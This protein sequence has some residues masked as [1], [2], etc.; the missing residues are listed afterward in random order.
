MGEIGIAIVIAALI[1][2]LAFIYIQHK[3]KE[4]SNFQSKYR[5]EVKKQIEQQMLEEHEVYKENL[6]KTAEEYGH[7]MMRLAKENYE[8]SKKDIEE[9]AKDL[10]EHTLREIALK[11]EA[12]EE[13]VREQLQELYSKYEAEVLEYNDRMSLLTPRLK[14]VEEEMARSRAEEQKGYF[15]R[16]N[17]TK[18]E[19]SDISKLSDI[20][21]DLTNPQI[22][23]KLIYENYVRRPF[24]EMLKRVLEGQDV[25]GI[26]KITYIRTGESYIGKST[27]IK[28]RWTEHV[29]SAYGVG[30]IAKSTL[31]TRMGK[32]GIQ[33]YS[34]EVIEEVPKDKLSSSEKYY[35]ELYNTKQQLNEREGG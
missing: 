9:S 17:L 2:S 10:W 25:C 18:N 11:K 7:N 20:L 30:T 3:R 24:S 1:L 16:I 4:V 19:I 12:E 8:R 15:Y 35:I 23:G 26:Y 21:L 31:H 27:N 28:R 32:D 5:E 13:R 14:A 22:L 33:N 34:F 6:K 29:K